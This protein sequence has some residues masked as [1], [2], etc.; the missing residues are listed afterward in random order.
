MKILFT[1][2]WL[3][4]YA[5]TELYVRDLAIALH[6]QGHHVEVYSPL[7]GKVA[8]EI[9]REGIHVCAHTEN[10]KEKPD[11]IHAHHFVQTMHALR[12]FRNVPAIYMLHDRSFAGDTPPHSQRILKY[13]AVDQICRDKLL[14][15]G[16]NPSKTDV[17]YNWVDTQ[18]FEQRKVITQ[19]PMQA[20]V[21][22]NYATPDNYYR[23]V[24]AACDKINIQLDVIGRSFQ[25]DTHTPEKVIANY[26]IIFAKGKAAIESLATG[27]ALIVCDFRGL[28]GMVTPENYQYFR[29]NNF[30]MATMTRAHDVHLIIEEIAKYDATQ[31]RMVSDR[32]RKEADFNRY[33]DQMIRLYKQVVRSY[34]WKKWWVRHDVEEKLIRTFEQTSALL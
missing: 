11:I 5:G 32:I 27:A 25:T 3:D 26:D 14:R 19:K 24:A 15:H 8:G 7:L 12:Q 1:N 20:L 9:A 6:H 13:V 22:S 29:E 34:R 2:I 30:G 16:I 17:L 31:V 10:L 28:G 33:V 18:R 21:F 4:H 23:F